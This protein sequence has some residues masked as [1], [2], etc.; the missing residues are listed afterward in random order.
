M[1][2]LQPCSDE[3]LPLARE[4]FRE[5]E[6]S[7]ATCLSFQGFEKELAG[8]PGEYAPP[9]GQL[10]VAFHGTEA[11]GCV[12]LRRIEDRICEMKRLYVRP[13]YRGQGMGKALA[14][15]IIQSARQAGY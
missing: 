8:L 14:Q 3:L 13:A 6:R 11:A 7:L 1:R 5:Y 4:L 15:A 2:T 10:L 9:A 12:A